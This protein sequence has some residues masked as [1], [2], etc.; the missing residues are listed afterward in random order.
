M[1]GRVS[2]STV[3]VSDLGLRARLT[4][5]GVSELATPARRNSPY[6]AVSGS[7]EP[8]REA[9]VY[10]FGVLLLELLSRE[11]PTRY[12]FDRGTKEFQ[13]VSLLKTAAHRL[14]L[15]TSAAAHCLLSTSAIPQT[16]RS[17]HACVAP[18]GGTMD[19]SALPWVVRAR[20]E[21]VSG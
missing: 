10:A 15:T 3:I 12:H 19:V 14:Y 5:F 17:P 4:H 11:E 13:W 6:V 18:G 2:P 20:E 9:D 16:G 1:H 21:R 8:S 7:T